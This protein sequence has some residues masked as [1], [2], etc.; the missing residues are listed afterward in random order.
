MQ[1][2]IKQNRSDI[3]FKILFNLETNNLIAETQNLLFILYI[4]FS[5]VY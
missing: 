3:L 1:T 4:N 2:D 5:Y